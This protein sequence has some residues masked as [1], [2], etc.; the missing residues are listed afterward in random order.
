MIKQSVSDVMTQSVHT[1][2]PEA[3]ACTVAKLFANNDIGS[4][5][6]V[7]SETEAILGIVTESDIMRQV[8]AGADIGAVQ[9]DTFLSQSLI[10]V[11][12]DEE[13]HTAATLMKEHSIQRLPVIDDGE[14]Q[15]MLT[16]SDL[17]DYLPRL[18]NTIRRTRYRPDA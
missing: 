8:A 7:D 10:S 5:I 9:V 18:R 12:S 13:I 11:T 1:I 6:V 14:L 17:T 4:A 16:T 2:T 3:T 15:G